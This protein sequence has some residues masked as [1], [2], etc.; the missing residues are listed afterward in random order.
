MPMIPAARLL[1]SWAGVLRYSMDVADHRAHRPFPALYQCRAGATALQATPDRAGLRASLA[2]DELHPAASGYRI[3]R[4]T[5]GHTIERKGPGAQPTSSRG[6]GTMRLHAPI[7]DTR[8][9][10]VC[11]SR[12]CVGYPT[13]RGRRGS[14][15]CLSARQS[16]W[17]PARTLVSRSGVATG[18]SWS[19]N[20]Q[21]RHLGRDPGE[22]RGP[23]SRLPARPDR[24]TRPLA[25]ASMAC[26][27]GLSGQRWLRADR[28]DVRLIGLSSNITR[29]AAFECR[30]E[31][32]MR[33]SRCVRVARRA[34]SRA[35]PLTL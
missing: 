5:T 8:P 22:G 35:T 15:L 26:V 31:E 16:G 19:V 27:S 2:R 30:I 3:D 10:T 29:R 6:H 24:S 14:P 23:M 13:R 9:R 28:Y 33:S 12:R 17:G 11:V 18:W 1:R 7:A 32:P 34:N 20:A 21:P 4:F 25:S